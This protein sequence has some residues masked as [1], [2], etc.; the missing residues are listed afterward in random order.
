MPRQGSGR[1]YTIARVSPASPSAG[2]ASPS[3]HARIP[4]FALVVLISAIW[5]SNFVAMKLVLVHLS[6][7][8][9]G[10]LRSLIAGLCLLTI[11]ALRGISFPR[12]PRIWREIALI[13]LFM[14]TLSSAAFAMGIERVSAGLAGLLSN[15]MPLFTLILAGPLLGERP[16]LI[17][18]VG[19]LI[20]FLGTAVIAWPNVALEGQALGIFF[21]MFAPASWA[22]GSILL[23]RHDLSSVH[24]LALVSMQLLMAATGIFVLSGVIE[25]FGRFEPHPDLWLP[26]LYA[27]LPALAFAYV[28]WVEI[29][30]RGSAVQASATAYMVPIFGVGF[31]A[32]WLGERLSV[33]ELL[34]GVLVLCGVAAVNLPG[35]LKADR[36][37][38]RTHDVAVAD[39]EAET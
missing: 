30:N 24:P 6:P 34:G 15:T 4:T 32:L 14:S 25:G 7:L 22:F 33:Q 31:G 28:L 19:L 39:R 11:C 35:V 1:F 16:G 18:W 36:E 38:T 23:K 5:G 29:L 10:S 2:T 21:V 8:V 27:A 37:N 17:A 3:W 12:E 9:M 26:L 13:A 20:G